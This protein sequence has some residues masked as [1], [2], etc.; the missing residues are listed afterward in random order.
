MPSNGDNSRRPSPNVAGKGVSQTK[1]VT[2]RAGNGLG[3]RLAGARAAK[4][5]TDCLAAQLTALTIGAS[6]VTGNT[7]EVVW[8]ATDFFDTSADAVTSPVQVV[9]FDNEQAFN[10]PSGGTNISGQSSNFSRPIRCEAWVLPKS[11]PSA[12]SSSSVVYSTALAVR[13]NGESLAIGYMGVQQTMVKPD[14]Q[15]DWTR[16]GSWDYEELFRKSNVLPAV[17]GTGVE[18]FRVAAL[19]PDTGMAMG[20]DAQVMYTIHFSQNLPAQSSIRGGVAAAQGWDTTPAYTAGDE[21]ALVEPIG[22]QN[23]S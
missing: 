13:P 11:N 18:L 14:F 17:S 10:G 6:G 7:K 15:V 3:K 4:T 8:R 22:L 16:I 19:D 21:F 12:N 20:A 5:G 1:K 23:R 9:Y 2:N